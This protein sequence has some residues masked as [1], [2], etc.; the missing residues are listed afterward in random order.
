MHHFTGISY[1]LTNGR[2][3]WCIHRANGL[4]YNSWSYWCIGVIGLLCTSNGKT[5]SHV[6]NQVFALPSILLDDKHMLRDYDASIDGL[7]CKLAAPYS[8]CNTQSMLLNVWQWPPSG[9]LAISSTLILPYDIHLLDNKCVSGEIN[10]RNS[11]ALT[12]LSSIY[13]LRSRSRCI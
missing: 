5:N 3:S 9:F 11:D 13:R 8:I 4:G 6:S 1:R 12:R 7:C 10:C 2:N